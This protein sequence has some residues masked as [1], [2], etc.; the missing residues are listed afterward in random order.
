MLS[1]KKPDY[2][3]RW[4]SPIPV[5]KEYAYIQIHE[6]VNIY[7]YT[8]KKNLES[9]TTLDGRVTINFFVPGT[10]QIYAYCPND[11]LHSLSW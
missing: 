2:K 11:D 8:Y 10:V 4:H 9:D 1:E 6:Y 7:Y 5:I 3:T